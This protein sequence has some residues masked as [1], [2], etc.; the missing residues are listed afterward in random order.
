MIQPKIVK[1]RDHR[2]EVVS[3]LQAFAAADFQIAQVSKA[4]AEQIPLQL[5][6]LWFDEIY[7]A[8]ERYF[9]CPKGDIDESEVKHFCDQFDDDECQAL[10]RF[11][12]C[13]ELRLDLLKEMEQELAGS[14]LWKNICRDAANTLHF[15]S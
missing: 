13:L 1:K 7:F 14:E 2:V 3:I 6:R 15:F 8:S 10:E 5:C 9:D 11:H 12:S 4:T